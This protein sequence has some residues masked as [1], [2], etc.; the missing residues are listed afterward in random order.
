MLNDLATFAGVIRLGD[1]SLPVGAVGEP[2]AIGEREFLIPAGPVTVV[3]SLDDPEFFR[4]GWNSWSPSGWRRITDVPLRIHDSPQRL[5]TAD[6]ARNDTPLAHSGSAV[7]AIAL[8][9][10]EILL[11]GALGLGAPRVGATA[12]T[13]WGTMEDPVA[14]WYFA[15]GP[16]VEVFARYAELLAERLGSRDASAG[17]VWCSWYSFYEEI[18][19]KSVRSAV[20]D[21]VE[22]RLPFDVVQLDDG[23]EPSVGDWVANDKFPSGMAATARTIT[24]AG[25]RAG[26]WLAPFI[27][28]PH[29]RFAIER[30]DLLIQ[31]EAG[32]PLVTGYNWGGPYYALDT[33]Q[34][35]VQEHLRELFTRVVGWGFTYL[36]L[37]FMYAAAIEGVRHAPVHREQAYRDAISL[38]REV[39]GDDVYLLGC[40]VPMLPS[41]GVFDGVRVGPDVAAFWENSE[42]PGDPTGVGTKNAF[43]ASIHR[44]WLRPCF[45]TDPDVVYFRRRRSL[46][47]DDQR[48]LLADVATVLGFRSTSDPVGWLTPDEVDELRDW[49]REPANVTRLGRY[50]FEVDDRLVDFGRFVDYVA[51]NSTNAN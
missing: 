28:L 41:I 49:L 11:L 34:P 36:K 26:L 51:P 2:R 19:E 33:T 13:L 48:Q 25:F 31:D 16:E 10:G 12:T 47:D 32:R 45:E 4:H 8:A 46:L 9:D 21:L 50:L 30:P 7:G 29:S 38:I 35:E 20:A 14:E 40:G 37:D 43:L 24:D 6:D 23:W 44:S 42:R 27:A 3:H 5:L 18:D 17:R 15:R 22:A 39:V 1:L